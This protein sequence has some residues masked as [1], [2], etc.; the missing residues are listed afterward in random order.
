MS[1]VYVDEKRCT[2]CGTCMTVCPTGAI[3]M[4]DNV[5]TIDQDRCTGCEACID[6]CPEGAIMAVTEERAL[7]PSRQ[8]AFESVPTLRQPPSVPEV[9]K[10]P[11][12]LGT[13]M[14]FLG[15]EIAPRLATYLVNTLGRR[16]SQGAAGLPGQKPSGSASGTQPRGGLRFRRRRRGG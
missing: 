1:Y 9:N 15:R 14:V 10:L 2:G 11:P 16:L 8:Q 4:V 6:V 13:A 7:V 3:A 12:V 5:A